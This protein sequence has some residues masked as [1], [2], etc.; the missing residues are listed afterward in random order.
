MIT[1]ITG[2]PGS[3]KTL[4]AMY[5]IKEALAQGR[6]VFTDI[7]GVSLDG[8][9]NI[10]AD[11]DWRDSP[12]GSLVVFD[13]V[14]RRWPS[15]GKP[16]QAPQ[17]DIRALETHRHTGHDIIVITQHPTLVHHHVRKLVGTHVHVRRASNA[18]VVSLFTLS[19][20]F[21]PK[22]K[23][24]LRNTDKQTWRYPKNLF[25]AYKSATAHTH[26]FKL[27]AKLKFLGMFLLLLVAG[28]AYLFWSW[29]PPWS[30]D[31]PTPTEPPRATGEASPA[32]AL[33]VLSDPSPI[34]LPQSHPDYPVMRLRQEVI[35]ATEVDTL[36]IISGCLSMGS[37][38]RCWDL[39]GMPLNTTPRQCSLLVQNMPRRLGGFASPSGSNGAN[40][41]TP[42][43]YPTFSSVESSA[44]YQ[45]AS[46]PADDWSARG[47]YSP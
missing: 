1:L 40:G 20:V 46:G 44:A 31:D 7:D 29:N 45:V 24:E 27:P 39:D 47:S 19:E 36:P 43:D 25:T 30:S 10:E 8:V 14:Q 32:A 4:R 23:N 5:L 37:D 12:E 42:G 16:G 26:T 22:D 28:L 33:V 38:C 6:A 2:T 11:F 21:D 18:Q 9:T 34:T 15:T 13:E 35:E 41:A 3:G 17:E